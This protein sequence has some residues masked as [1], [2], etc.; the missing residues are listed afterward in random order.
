MGKKKE[1]SQ[2]QIW[3]SKIG[4]II[5]PYRKVQIRKDASPLLMEKAESI[6]E[7]LYYAL[8]RDPDAVKETLERSSTG[9]DPMEFKVSGQTFLLWQDIVKISKN[10]TIVHLRAYTGVRPDNK[11]G[12]ALITFE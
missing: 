1:T 5:F 10:S 11:T 6:L 8:L 7:K 2:A 9:E 3:A 4:G 12:T